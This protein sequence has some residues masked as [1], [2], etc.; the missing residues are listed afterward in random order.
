MPIGAGDMRPEDP[1]KM[2]E[3]WRMEGRGGVNSGQ[4]MTCAR[5]LR[6]EQHVRGSWGRSMLFPGVG[7]GVVCSTDLC[8]GGK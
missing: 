6:Q 3:S 8:T 5:A 2:R 4:R 7:D 1:R